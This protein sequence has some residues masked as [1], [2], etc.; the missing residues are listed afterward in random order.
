MTL[1]DKYN[2][3][4]KVVKKNGEVYLIKEYYDKYKTKK[5][6]HVI[7]KGIKNVNAY[8]R[9]NGLKRVEEMF[10]DLYT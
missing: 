9:N 2:S 4:Y 10:E 3:I 6:V 7:V 5:S 1:I 8:A